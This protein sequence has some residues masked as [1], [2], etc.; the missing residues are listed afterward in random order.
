MSLKGLLTVKDIQKARDFPNAAHD[1]SGRLLVGAAVG[2]GADLEPRLELLVNEGVD[3]VCVDTAHGHS[4]GVLGAVRRIK[5]AWPNLPVIAGN[6][7]T[8]EGVE[9]LVGVGA[10]V[11]VGAGV[12]E[13]LGVAEGTAVDSSVGL[14]SCSA[15]LHPAKMPAATANL[16][17]SRLLTPPEHSQ[18]QPRLLFSFIVVPPNLECVVKVPYNHASTNAVYI[19]P[20][21]L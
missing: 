5:T 2:V 17:K 12:G 14:T 4:A 15:G 16:I 21:K 1:D 18:E 13:V 10:D 19:M 9:A 7:V 20:D 8:A 3:V 6:V 11:A